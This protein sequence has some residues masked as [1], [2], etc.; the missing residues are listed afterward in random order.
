MVVEKEGRRFRVNC[1]GEGEREGGRGLFEIKKRPICD[2][3]LTRKWRYCV[4][5][6]IALFVIIIIYYCCR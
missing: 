5:L 6:D 3:K 4:A 2:E 1:G